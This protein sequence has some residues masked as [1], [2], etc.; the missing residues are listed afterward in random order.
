MPPHLQPARPAAGAPSRAW[1]LLRWLLVLVIAWDQA[2]S[3]L[4]H[5]QH[6]SGVD[7]RWL[8][9]L[10]HGAMPVLAHA[11]HG[12]EDLSLSHALLAVR[13]KLDLDPVFMGEDPV[14]GIVANLFLSLA[15]PSPAIHSLAIPDTPEPR[16]T[17]RSLPPAGRAPPL[18]T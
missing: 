18:H 10:R 13:P 5:H 4:H 7:T 6:D 11:E 3:P 15:P 16:R 9:A 8:G 1:W 14:E 2:G 17:H 12:D